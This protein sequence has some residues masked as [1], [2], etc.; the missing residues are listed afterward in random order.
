MNIKEDDVVYEKDGFQL[1]IKDIKDGYNISGMIRKN[2][3]IDNEVSILVIDDLYSTGAT[4][5]EVCKVLRNDKNVKIIYCLA[6][7]KTKG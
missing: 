3:N 5:N 6:M 7:T 1:A 2:K 4:L